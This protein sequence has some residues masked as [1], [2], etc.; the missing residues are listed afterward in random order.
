[1]GPSG[2]AGPEGPAG[3]AGPPGPPG[4]SGAGTSAYTV[5]FMVTQPADCPAGF[6]ASSYASVSGVAD[7][8]IVLSG[9]GLFLGGTNGMAYGEDFLWA[10]I[11]N[12]SNLGTGTNPTLCWQTYTSSFGHP[13]VAYMAYLGGGGNNCPS[14]YTYLPVASMRGANGYFYMGGN[15]HGVY[16]GYLDSWNW[17]ASAYRDGYHFRYS[18]SGQGGDVDT[19][20]FRVMGVDADPSTAQGVYPVVLGVKAS[21]NCPTGYTYVATTNLAGNNNDAYLL[22]NDNMSAMGGLYSWGFGGEN[23]LQSSWSSTSG[24]QY[25][26][27][28]YP[29]TGPPHTTVIASSGSGCPSGYQSVAVANVNGSG[30]TAYIGQTGHGLW[31]GGAQP[32]LI[33]NSH[34]HFSNTLTNDA[35][36]VCYR[37]DNVVSFP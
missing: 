11:A 2:P 6:N 22:L 26:F 32:S 33:D 25:C 35:S 37:I 3:D 5:A 29:L 15:A 7:F 10:Q 30:G 34:G 36:N 12:S 4:S 20:C 19:V 21:S 13:S 1:M 27:K 28:H 17:Q 8:N 9:S 31:I 24:I 16:F 14:G 23:Y 18:A